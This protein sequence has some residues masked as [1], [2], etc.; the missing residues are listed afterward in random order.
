MNKKMQHFTPII[1]STFILAACLISGN[2][3]AIT[4]GQPDGNAHPYVVLIVFD[5]AP[6]HP[7]HYSTGT[8]LS[9]TVVLCSGH[10]AEGMVGGRVWFAE[11][12][13]GN[14]DYPN[15][16][17]SSHEIAKI[18]TDPQ[19]V[20]GGGHGVPDADTHDVG[21]LILANPVYFEPIR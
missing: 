10:S 17:P 5:D 3:Y 20:L 15:G 8:L 11:D 7:A 2:V 4:N 9:S 13:T 16:G 14:L 6:G 19:F 18:Y 12:L 21:I 1:V